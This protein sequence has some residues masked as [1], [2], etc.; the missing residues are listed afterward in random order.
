MKTV[1]RHLLRA[2]LTAFFVLLLSTFGLYVISDLFDNLDDFAS[3]VAD[4]D[5]I[6]L[7]KL[8]GTYYS[9]QL[10]FFLN[11]A[12]HILIVLSLLATLIV[13]KKGG[14][15]I[16]YCAAGIPLYRCFVPLVGGAL[17]LDTV[18]AVNRE[19]IVPDIAHHKHENR[20]KQSGTTHVVQPVY[21]Q[22][23]G[24][25]IGG[26]RLIL[27]PP[28][29]SGAQ[30]ILP[31]GVVENESVLRAKEAF[32]VRPGGDYGEGWVLKNVRPTYDE[33]DLTERGR[34]IVAKSGEGKDV[35]VRTPIDAEMLYAKGRASDLQSTYGILEWIHN[36]AFPKTQYGELLM[37]VHRRLLQ[38]IVSA[39]CA[40]IVCIFVFRRDSRGVAFSA[41]LGMTAASMVSVVQY[42]FAALGKLGVVDAAF[43]A[44]S[45]VLFTGVLTCWMLQTV[46]T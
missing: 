39:A 37:E 4:G 16:I 33:L 18:I 26:E 41:G 43:A 10:C 35:Y 11:A 23:S 6:E 9:H 40:L 34:S 32:F 20:G 12:G 19:F 44:W 21:D 1:D 45:P 13:L 28:A 38:P 5:R 3:G 17:I 24:I 22:S 7:L 14:Q 29:L 31:A 30:L 2:Y 36:P 15:L 8:I 46:E 27:D 25:F 42:S